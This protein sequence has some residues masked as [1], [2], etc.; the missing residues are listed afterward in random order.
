MDNVKNLTTYS[1]P[2]AVEW[3]PAIFNRICA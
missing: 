1:L 2:L 3:L